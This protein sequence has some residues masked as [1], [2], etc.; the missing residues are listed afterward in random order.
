MTKFLKPVSIIAL[1]L[2]AFPAFAIQGFQD[3]S[4]DDDRQE[5]LRKLTNNCSFVE[6]DGAVVRGS[7]CYLMAGQKRSARAVMSSS[8]RLAH[9]VLVLVEPLESIDYNV[10]FEVVS[11][12]DGK[13]ERAAERLHNGNQ[14][15]VYE[16]GS[17]AL[18]Y[19]EKWNAFLNI[20]QATFELLYASEESKAAV[21]SNFKL[22]QPAG[23]EY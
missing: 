14:V 16:E 18:V 15:I 19:G 23:H 7:S 3:L 4:F 21:R 22:D 17:I 6:E 20:P 13:Y 1:S 5:V 2:G 12:L 11:G 9:V 10:L 8:G